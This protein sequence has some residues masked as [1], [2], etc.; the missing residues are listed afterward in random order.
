M[1]VTQLVCTLGVD[2]ASTGVPLSVSVKGSG[3][4]VASFPDDTDVTAA[5][6]VLV[7]DG[8]SPTQAHVTDLDD[9]YTIYLATVTAYQS[10]SLSG[11]VA[12]SIDTSVVTTLREL[13]AALDAIYLA[14]QSGHGGL[15]P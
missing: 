9:A 4:P 13:K 12:V 1:A 11:N 6:G 14:A 3:D 5:V 10:T 7:A 15:T 2:A 8:A